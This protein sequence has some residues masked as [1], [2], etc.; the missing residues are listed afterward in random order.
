MTERQSV[1]DNQQL[2]ITAAR[3]L[4]PRSL[5]LEFSNGEIRLFDSHR[6]RGPQFIPLMNEEY[7]KRPV[8]R[9]GDLGWEEL[10]VTASARYIYDR[11]VPYD[12]NAVAKE[13]IPTKKEIMEE[14]LAAILFPLMAIAGIFGLVWWYIHQ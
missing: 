8:I 10:E 13:H 4:N 1:S 9:N 14:R 5:R 11:S 6:L 12:D 2:Q 3:P 7:F